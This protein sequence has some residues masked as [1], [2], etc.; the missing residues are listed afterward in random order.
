MNV[1]TDQFTFDRTKWGIKYN[2][3]SF[4]EGLKD[5][6]ISNDIG[7]KISLVAK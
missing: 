7:L 1:S 2:S 4:F 3:A 5:K 6:A